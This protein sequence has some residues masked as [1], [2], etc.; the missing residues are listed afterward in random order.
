VDDPLTAMS[1]SGQQL[2]ENVGHGA[3]PGAEIATLQVVAD[4]IVV[5]DHDHVNLYQNVVEN[6]A[7]GVLANDTDPISTDALSVSAVN[8]SVANVGTP[9]QGLY[10][11]LTLAADGSYSYTATHALPDDGVGFDTFSY[12]A[13]TGTGGRAT[14]DLTIVVVGSDKHYFGGTPDTMIN[15]GRPTI[16]PPRER[17]PFRLTIWSR[18]SLEIAM[19]QKLELSGA[20]RQRL[21]SH[22]DE[23]SRWLMSAF[24]GD[25]WT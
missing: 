13:E 24:E 12:T 9:V 3:D 22:D 16:R 10:G 8:G 2:I 15:G 23:P 18:S 25:E 1:A 14:T 4:P 6:A 17:F 7:N 21:E 19:S 11:A 5:A 20:Q